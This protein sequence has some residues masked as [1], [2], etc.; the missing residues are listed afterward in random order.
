MVRQAIEPE[1]LTVDSLALPQGDRIFSYI[2]PGKVTSDNASQGL[3]R[4]ALTI[5]DLPP[6][7]CRPFRPT[8]CPL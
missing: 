2:L 1:P 4:Y 3:L 8:V 7:D 5:P 6:D